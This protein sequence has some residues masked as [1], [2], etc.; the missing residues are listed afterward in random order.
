MNFKVFAVK[1]LYSLGIGHRRI[2][3]DESTSISTPLT[4]NT[5]VISP[6]HNTGIT[7]PVHHSNTYPSQL[8]YCGLPYRGPGDNQTVPSPSRSISYQHPSHEQVEVSPR[9]ASVSSNVHLP[10]MARQ[11]HEAGISKPK[12]ARIVLFIFSCFL[13][14]CFLLTNKCHG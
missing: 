4:I 12:T 7:N 3:S 10:K 11:G 13:Q 5:G 14:L 1:T 2:G 8:D 6:V 9:S